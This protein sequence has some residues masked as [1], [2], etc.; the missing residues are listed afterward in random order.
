MISRKE[1]GKMDTNNTMP[2]RAQGPQAQPPVNPS[3]GM[4]PKKT[5]LYE[6]ISKDDEEIIVKTK[7]KN[8]SPLMGSM[9]WFMKLTFYID[10]VRRNHGSFFH[11]LGCI[12]AAFMGFIYL[13]GLITLF[14]SFYARARLPLYLED[15][16]TRHHLK[17][18]SL[19][20]ADYS[21]TQIHVVNL[22]DDANKYI[23]P[24]FFVF[25]QP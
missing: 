10:A 9:V 14:L 23:I 7:K 22:H 20:M 5:D 18:D 21:L 2:P 16:F 8:Q 19:K 17:Y 25:S 3:N 11:V 4:G 6:A 1:R 13:G 24:I 12:W 15:F